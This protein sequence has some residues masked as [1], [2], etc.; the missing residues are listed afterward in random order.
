MENITTAVIWKPMWSTKTPVPDRDTK[1]P[2]PLNDDHNP[3]TIPW[4]LGLSGYP[5]RLHSKFITFDLF[6]IY[7]NL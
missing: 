1:R 3:A 6:N 5:A 2:A 4:V 7:N